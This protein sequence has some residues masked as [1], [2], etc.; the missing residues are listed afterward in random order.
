MTN[1]VFNQS[2]FLE[3]LEKGYCKQTKERYEG[4]YRNISDDQKYGYVQYRLPVK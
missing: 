1:D 3:V 2:M 4:I